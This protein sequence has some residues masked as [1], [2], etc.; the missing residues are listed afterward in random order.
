ME[1]CCS[2]GKSPGG[3]GEQRAFLVGIRM[4]ILMEE[5]IL[6]VGLE[7]LQNGFLSLL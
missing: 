2:N 6:E 4:E 7:G 3:R 1:R 5:V